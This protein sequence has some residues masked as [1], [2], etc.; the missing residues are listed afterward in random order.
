MKAQVVYEG[1]SYFDEHTGPYGY[2]KVGVLIEGRVMW[3][4]LQ[5]DSADTDNYLK[6]QGIAERI[7]TALNNDYA[8]E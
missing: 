2:E 6:W 5:S 4:A 1:D 3:L 8:K 7:A